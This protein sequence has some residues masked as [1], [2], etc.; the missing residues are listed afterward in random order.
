VYPGFD[1]DVLWKFRWYSVINQMLVWT[2]L[3]LGFGA[4]LDRLDRPRRSRPAGSSAG[5]AGAAGQDS[6]PAKPVD[7]AS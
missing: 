7:A 1:A 3:A 2:V 4:L 5:A 6:Q